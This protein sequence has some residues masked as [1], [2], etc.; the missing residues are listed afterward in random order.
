MQRCKEAYISSVVW[1]N[2]VNILVTCSEISCRNI[3]S[4]CIFRI[5]WKFYWS[6]IMQ[7]LLEKGLV[8]SKYRT[9]SKRRTP[10]MEYFKW[11]FDWKCWMNIRRNIWWWSLT[12]YFSVRILFQ[13]CWIYWFPCQTP[14]RDELQGDSHKNTLH[15]K[16]IYIL[17]KN[18]LGITYIIFSV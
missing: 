14:R 11:I 13:K 17:R 5:L 3:C 8:S 18:Q 7:S 9:F 6:F 2:L 1:C 15:Q 4:T 16:L 10:R 12:Q